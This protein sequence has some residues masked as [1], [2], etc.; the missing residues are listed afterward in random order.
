MPAEAEPPHR[1]SWRRHGERGRRRLVNIA[2]AFLVVA[3]SVYVF[4]GLRD[5][6]G[7]EASE[8][9]PAAAVTIST[10]NAALEAAVRPESIPPINRGTKATPAPRRPTRPVA[11]PRRLVVPDHPVDSTQL[12][13][14]AG[15]AD[16]AA[17]RR[18]V[19]PASSV[20]TLRPPPAD[21]GRAR[22]ENGA[23]E[24]RE[25]AGYVPMAATAEEP[26]REPERAAPSRPARPAPAAGA[27]ANGATPDDELPVDRRKLEDELRDGVEECY[28][29][30]RSKDLDRL[31]KLYAPKSPA[32]EDKLRRLT[33]ILRTEPWKA[34]VGR[35]VDGVRELGSRT[36][37]AEF[38]FRLTWRGSYGGRLSSQPI[39][40]VELARDG[41]EWIRSSCRIVGSPKL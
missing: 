18:Q 11:R 14:T 26:P 32:D 2:A 12:G 35:R 5:F 7:D 15:V 31:A 40:R 21:T 1:S 36:A 38:S 34:V 41:E 28:G 4:G 37:A 3:G 25:A 9:S 10:A 8:R 20:A 16:T 29:A 22:S 19:P 17:A 13:A 39:F 23:G 24:A 6:W 30:V 27:P 33:R